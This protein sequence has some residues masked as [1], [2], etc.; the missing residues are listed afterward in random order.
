MWWLPLVAVADPSAL[1]SVKARWKQVHG[2]KS[3][4]ELY[5][6]EIDANPQKRDWAAFG[7]F[8]SSRVIRQRVH[9]ASRTRCSTS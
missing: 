4:G 9:A 6:F 2:I 5:A 7:E 8:S 1:D 3:A